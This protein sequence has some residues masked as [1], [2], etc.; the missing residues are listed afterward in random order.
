MTGRLWLSVALVLTLSGCAVRPA[1]TTAEPTSSPALPQALAE[2]PDTDRSYDPSA[3]PVVQVVQQVIPAVVT[4][5]SQT[6]SL[7]VFGEQ[8]QRGV[9][10]GFVVDPD[11]VILTNNHVVEGAEDLTVTTQDGRDVD[12]RVVATDPQH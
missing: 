2:S 5:T 9:G 1:T 11:G 8:T 7:G 4:V 3:D 6:R 12:A 10:T